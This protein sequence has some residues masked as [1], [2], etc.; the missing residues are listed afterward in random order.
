MEPSATHA[1]ATILLVD[2]N[3]ANLAALTH[4]LAMYGFRMLVAQQGES[5]IQIAQRAQPDLILLDVRLPG[6]DG[7]ETCRRLKADAVTKEIPVLFMTVRTEA[8]DKLK[9]FQAGA[10]DYITKPFQVGEVLARL[11]THLALRRLQQQLEAQNAQLQ[12]EVAER[13]Q[14]EEALQRAHGELEQ[15]VEE[16]TEALSK[17]EA[18]YYISHSLI[19]IERLPDLLQAV[20]DKVAEALPADRVMLTL[21]DLEKQQ[22]PYFVKGG[23]GIEHLVTVSFEELWEGLSGWVLRELKPAL[24]PKGVP[25]PRESPDVQRRRAETNAGAVIVTPLRYREKTLGTMAAINRLDQPDF[26]QQDMELMMA[27]A[28]QAA[29]TIENTR[30]LLS[31]RESEERHST[32]INTAQEGIWVLDTQARVS[33]VNQRLADLLDYE[34]EEMLG[35]AL[36]DFMDDATRRVTEVEFERRKQGIKGSYDLRLRRRNGAG[37]WMIVS[38]SPLFDRN[39]EFAGAFEM[40]TDITERKRVEEALRKARAELERRVEARTHELR[41]ANEQLIEEIEERKRVET[42][43]RQSEEQLRTYTQ[44]LQILH[45]IDQ[46]ILA[47]Q[48]PEAI[49]QAALGNIRALVPCRW[50]SVAVFDDDARAIAVLATHANNHVEPVMGARRALE[51]PQIV[52]AL[53][54]GEVQVVDDTALLTSPPAIIAP[55]PATDVRSYVNMPLIAAGDLLGVLSLEA[56]QPRAFAPEHVAIAREVADQIAVAIRQTRLYAAEQRARRLAET[57]RAANLALTQTLDLDTILDTLLEYLGQLVPYDSAS[58]MVY[59]AD[60]RLIVRSV[61]GEARWGDL[62]LTRDLVL[63]AAASPHLRALLATQASILIADTA[64]APLWAQHGGAADAHSWLG[65]PLI[66]GGMVIGLYALDKRQPGFFTDEHRQVAESLAAQAAVAMQNARLFA[67]VSAARA[68]LQAVSRQ[69]VAVQEAERAQIA[70]DL[71][72]EIGQ[73]LTGL[74]LVLA[75]GT[76]STP[77]MVQARLAEAQALVNDLTTRV[78][79]LSL[80]LR[81]AMLDDLGLLPTLLWYVKRYTA[82]TQIQVTM[83][84]TG[85]DR[86]LAPDVEIAAYR[87]VQ[88]ALTNVARH[89]GVRDVMVWLWRTEE[90]LGVQ[91]EDQGRGFTPEDVLAAHTSSGL[92]GMVERVR[93]LGGQ[94]TIESAPGQGTRL[95]AELPL[96][97]PLQ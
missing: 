13:R 1:V 38:A 44:R 23:P 83:K 75:I 70:R 15:Q 90:T 54:R 61:R 28:N 57:L 53:R 17:T 21:F 73:M 37:I 16:R 69:L 48:S 63:D 79:E 26:T 78:R 68:R 74:K 77:A 52:N 49:A 31:L 51:P 39:G 88:E 66:A 47:A 36:F 32:I 86:R 2:D 14:A 56:D 25:D 9:G 34:V 60:A 6:M 42:A 93:L 40:M 91:I 96:G 11:K 84:H 29:M 92:T 59:E 10:V 19:T 82:Q 81:P 65:V 5:G 97:A 85:L 41:Q 55:V 71:H 4:A 58:A 8:E 45:A 64:T 72:D 30:L 12:Q 35:R 24:S 33:F 18:L 3:P 62:A 27:M 80:D 22:V 7:F 94:L 87:I 20:V 76:R 46:A 43:L 89:A 95:T 50:A 67:Q